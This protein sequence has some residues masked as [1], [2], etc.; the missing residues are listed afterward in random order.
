M[1][2]INPTLFTMFHSYPVVQHL[3]TC[4]RLEGLLGSRQVT[5]HQKETSDAARPHFNP[6]LVV[7]LVYISC[8]Q[9]KHDVTFT[10]TALLISFHFIFTCRNIVL[11]VSDKTNPWKHFRKHVE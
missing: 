7:V 9:V 2:Q 11:Q 10:P 5:P 4:L 1:L 8:L 6:H 3:C